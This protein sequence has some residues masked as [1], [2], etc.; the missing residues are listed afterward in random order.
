MLEHGGRLRLAAQHYDTPLSDWL[1]L[2]TGINPDVY[3]VQAIDP[4]CWQR[5]PVSRVRQ[6][7]AS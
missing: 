4:A 1:D 3:P 7:R 6:R 5:L 2:S